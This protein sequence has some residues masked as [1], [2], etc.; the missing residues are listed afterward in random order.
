MRLLIRLLAAYNMLVALAVTVKSVFDVPQPDW[1]LLSWLM[2]P[3]VV[4]SLAA[5]Y[6]FKRR[7][8]ADG[9]SA[10]D[11]VR[12]LDVNVHFF[13]AAVLFVGYGFQWSAYLNDLAWGRSGLSNT[14]SLWIYV[15][16]LVIMVAA[17]MGVR[18][19]KAAGK[20]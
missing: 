5:A 4:I 14:G 15:D 2:A 17:V 10:E 19:W 7:S 16:T 1:E 20:T 18:M 3:A 6:W 9:R 12:F 11:T 13:A 8:D